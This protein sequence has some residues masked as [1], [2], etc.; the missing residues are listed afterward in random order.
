MARE[1]VG[2]PAEPPQ[3]G[4]A[5]QGYLYPGWGHGLGCALAHP[6]WPGDIWGTMEWGEAEAQVGAF[7]Q[8]Q[9]WGEGTL[10]ATIPILHPTQPWASRIQTLSA[11]L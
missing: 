7:R 5:R 10:P 3:A 9:G 2:L 4:T 1:E 6:A 8:A 11:M